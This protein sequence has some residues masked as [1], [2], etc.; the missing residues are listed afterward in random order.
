MNKPRD[1]KQ[2]RSTPRIRVPGAVIST[3]PDFL[4]SL[5]KM[6]GTGEAGVNLGLEIEVPF[7][8]IV[9]EHLQ[10]LRRVKPGLVF[11]DLESEPHV[12]LKFAQFLL[13]SELVGAMIGVGR[14]LSPDLLLSAMQAGISEYLP[15][16]VTAEALEAALDRTWRKT[17]KKIEGPDREPGELIVV[18]GAK[19]G[20]GCTTLATN[21]GIEL[22]RLSRKKTLIVDLDLELGETALLLGMEPK[23]SVADLIR[24][25]HRVDANLL[26]SYI[27]RHETGVELLSAPFQPADFEAVSGDRV[28]QVLDFLRKHYGFVIVDA[29]KTFTP[30]TM[31]AFE[32]AD[33]ALLVTTSDLP[34]L[35]NLNRSLPLLKSI[36]AKRASGDWLHLVVNRYESNQL[37]SL[38]EIQRTLKMEVFWTLRND[39]ASVMG[40]INSGEPVVKDSKS[41]Y[42]K[43]VRKLASEIADVPVDD[44]GSGILGTLLS[45]F[46]RNG[47]SERGTPSSRRGKMSEVKA[48]EH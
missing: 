13:D 19:G 10:S 43:D 31:A 2:T 44:G 37:I 42:A 9:D 6:L 45:P 34:S 12:G 41:S 26:A 46:R 11:L 36:Q 14:D 18:F 33:R 23:F 7:T 4:Q 8:E 30:A 21:L 25:F 27:E 20:S 47:K 22:H 48:D 38:Q 24:N 5:R 17:G 15:K 1:S 28:R 16:P 29:P 35:R 40:S 32:T 39:Y 3:D